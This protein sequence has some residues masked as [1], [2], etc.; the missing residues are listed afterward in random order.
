[1]GAGHGAITHVIQRVTTVVKD[2]NEPPE[3][4]DNLQLQLPDR[5]AAPH[6]ACQE[7]PTYTPS[8]ARPTITGAANGGGLAGTGAGPR[9]ERVWLHAPRQDASA[10]AGSPSEPLMMMCLGGSFW[11]LYVHAL[12]ALAR[13]IAD[14][15]SGHADVLAGSSTL[16]RAGG[17]VGGSAVAAAFGNGVASS[18]A[19]SPT[20]RSAAH[21]SE[22][23]APGEELLPRSRLQ[24]LAVPAAGGVPASSNG[25]VN[26]AAVKCVRMFCNPL[27]GDVGIAQHADGSMATFPADDLV[28]G[29]AID[30]AMFWG[31]KLA[32]DG[33]GEDTPTKKRTAEG[34][35]AAGGSSS[36]MRADAEGAGS[37]ADESSIDSAQALRAVY[38]LERPS[39]PPTSGDLP[40]GSNPSDVKQAL[41]SDAA[42]LMA[43]GAGVSP[44]RKCV[45]I[46]WSATAADARSAVQAL[47][48]VSMLMRFY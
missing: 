46:D 5:C 40:A 33:T 48:I 47:R 43:T 14:V 22:G 13:R 2:C 16:G 1:M 10:A 28:V 35:R 36:S 6:A 25:T 23:M 17:S 11:K 32:A 44:I 39:L 26:G 19:A 15:A 45:G 34:V 38:H 30:S 42:A 9:A 24:E 3:P 41:D 31:S 7:R 21:A 4:L 20:A 37:V 27:V 8:D 12:Q 29:G 18:A